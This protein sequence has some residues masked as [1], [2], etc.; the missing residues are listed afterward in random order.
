[1]SSRSQNKRTMP[2][3]NFSHW[4]S[5]LNEGGCSPLATAGNN[6]QSGPRE[7]FG[8]RGGYGGSHCFALT[9]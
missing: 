4:V 3:A 1:M 7:P 6:E 8:G 2:R 9:L 5:V